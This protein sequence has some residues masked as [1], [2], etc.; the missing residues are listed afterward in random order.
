MLHNGKKY[1]RNTNIIVKNPHPQTPIRFS[2][3]FFI[4]SS[5]ER[6][7]TSMGFHPCNYSHFF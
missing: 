2:R 7:L 5:Q 6:P 4:I 1:K 3:D